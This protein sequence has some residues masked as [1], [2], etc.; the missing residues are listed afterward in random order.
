MNKTTKSAILSLVIATALISSIMT[1]DQNSA[2]AGKKKINEASEGIGQNSET[3]QSSSCYSENDTTLASC[4]NL[5]AT[6]NLNFGNN[7]AGQQ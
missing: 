7:A 6:F 5:D 3:Y 1:M 4:N 2:F